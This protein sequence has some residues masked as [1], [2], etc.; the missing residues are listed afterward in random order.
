MQYFIWLWTQSSNTTEIAD[1]LKASFNPE[2][3]KQTNYS[4]VT[5]EYVFNTTTPLMFVDK[6]LQVG[7]MPPFTR[8]LWSNPMNESHT[9]LEKL[10]E[11]QKTYSQYEIR[12]YT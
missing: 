5:T 4:P 7:A 10:I 1:Y 8:L 3:F 11:Y 9:S 12:D 6:A 2:Y